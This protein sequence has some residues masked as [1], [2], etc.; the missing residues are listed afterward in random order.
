MHQLKIMVRPVL[1]KRGTKKKPKTTC[2]LSELC[3]DWRCVAAPGPHSTP[4]RRSLQGLEVRLSFS[5][6]QFTAAVSC[7]ARKTLAPFKNCSLLLYALPSRLHTTPSSSSST[8]TTISQW[9]ASWQTPPAPVVGTS[10]KQQLMV[11][12]VEDA[13]TR[14]RLRRS[15]SSIQ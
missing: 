1:Y 3:S 8:F 13:A 10:P 4:Q 12:G 6:T 2:L 7:T 14:S 5:P 9:T 15:P 11:Q